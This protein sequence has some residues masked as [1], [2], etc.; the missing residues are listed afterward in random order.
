MVGLD[1]PLT[2][3]MNRDQYP[4][5]ENKPLDAVDEAS[6]ESF[7]GSDPPGWIG[8]TLDDEPEDDGKEQEED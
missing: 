6:W 8:S 3:D 2:E 4:A 1:D 5:S 7:P